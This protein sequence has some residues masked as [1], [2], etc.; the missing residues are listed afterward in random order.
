L[1]AA[2]AATAADVLRIVELADA[3]R[4]ELAAM[5]G[6]VLWIATSGHGPADAATFEE[7]LERHDAHLAVGAI[8]DVVVGYGAVELVPLTG[9]GEELANVTELF[10]E[11]GARAIGVG[12]AILGELARFALANNAVG[13]DVVAL[14]GHRAAKSFFE[15]QG[16]VARAI[17]MHASAATLRDRE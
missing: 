3:L 17:V 16:L 9:D 12:E 10:V 2:R 1:E 7:M 8:D 13:L 6:G 14:P 15:D 11:P 4:V 5:R